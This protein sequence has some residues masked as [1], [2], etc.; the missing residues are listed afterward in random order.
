MTTP[1]PAVPD[2][3]WIQISDRMQVADLNALIS[4][5]KDLHNRLRENPRIWRGH[6]NS[7]TDTQLQAIAR[8][9]PVLEEP[10]DLLLK[11]RAMAT[12]AGTGQEGFDGDGGRADQSALHM[13]EEV[14]VA[15]DGTVYIADTLNHRVRRVATDGVITTVAG[16][17]QGSFGGDGGP[18]RQAA[19]SGPRS[20]AVGPN[21]AL[22]IADLGNRRVRCVAAD[23]TITTVAG[24]GQSGFGGDH[25]PAH[26]AVLCLPVG[27]AVGPDGTVYIADM[28]NHCVRRITGDNVI[29][30]FAGTGRDGFGGDHGPSHQSL[31]RCPVGVAVGPD[32]TVYIADRSNHRV[33]RIGVDGIITTVAGIGQKG[34]GGDGGPADRAVLSGP[35]SVAVGSNGTLYVAD[36]FNHRVRCITPDGIVATLAGTGQNGF[37]GDGGP[38]PQ[39]LLSHPQGVAVGPDGLV[40]VV[41]G[42]R[43][44]RFGA[45]H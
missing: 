30:T 3:V 42:S 43:L 26:E 9:V 23:G 21:G 8:T 34:F 25:G 33:R 10:V 44:R 37:D 40:H 15:Q 41:T 16:T 22:Y 19:L 11:M 24:T 6:L 20:V 1:I 2:D 38:A 12:L 4:V 28:G 5:D 39:A 13:P 18:A 29:S 35:R 31:L 36:T 14:A 27:V 32:G 45:P 17:G 7:C